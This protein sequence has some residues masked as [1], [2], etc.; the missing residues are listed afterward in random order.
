[1]KV[2]WKFVL[3]TNF[4]SFWEWP[5]YTGITVYPSYK[6][7]DLPKPNLTGSYE[8]HFVGLPA[9]NTCPRMTSDTWSGDTSALLKASLMHTVPRSWAVTLLRVPLRLPE[10]IHLTLQEPITTAADDTICNIFL[11][12]Q[13][14]KKKNKY[15]ISWESSASRRFSWNIM[16]YLLFLKIGKTWNCCL[17]QIIGGALWVNLYIQMDSS[18]WFNTIN[19]G[20]SI[21]YI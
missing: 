6:N 7:N 17:L 2:T 4:R 15:N 13:K 5:F 10:K 12:F 18:F 3:K 8:R 14:K 21:V 9:V 1:M 11:N 19:L 16:P 20:W